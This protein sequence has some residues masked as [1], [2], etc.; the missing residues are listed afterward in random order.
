MIE[1]RRAA[2]TE[3]AAHEASRVAEEGRAAQLTQ[4][5]Q[6]DEKTATATVEVDDGQALER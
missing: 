1:Q 5:A 6:E 2:E 4:W 3:Q